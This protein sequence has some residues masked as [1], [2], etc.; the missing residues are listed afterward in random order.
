MFSP[1]ISVIMPVYNTSRYLKIAID[2][3]LNQ[4]FENFELIV[5]DDG[6]TDESS[7]ILEG[8]KNRNNRIKV[9]SQTN[10]GQSIAKNIAL[11]IALGKYVYFM[12]SDD[13]LMEDA[14][15]SCYNKAE[16]NSL[17]L[18]FFDAT[19]FYE[20]NTKPFGF[21]YNR[22]NVVNSSITY[23]GFEVLNLLLLNKVFRASPCVH[24]VR[25]D[26]IENVSL[27]FF[28]GI[29]HED[30]LFT[31]Q[32]YINSKRVGYIPKD[33][34]NRRVRSNSTMTKK[35]SQKNIDGYLTVV[36]EWNL[37]K[38]DKSFQEQSTVNKLIANIINSVAYQSSQLPLNERLQVIYFVLK[39]G[40]AGITF[41]N[42][43]ILLFPVTIKI[44]PLLK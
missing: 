37:I 6:S 23:E 30:E 21:D 17:D 25:R 7:S 1:E 38:Q 15:M 24:F 19:I 8:Y 28:P 29:I 18:V 27:R 12:D 13:I 2:S 44:K 9:L 22:K 34:F 41:K 35:F 40:F 39:E 32:L 16:T 11:D 33:F 10:S 26:I 43:I 36:N 42:L 5:V 14:L 3:I 4:S 31:P 20:E